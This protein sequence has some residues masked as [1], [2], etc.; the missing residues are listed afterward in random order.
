MCVAY[1]VAG[2]TTTPANGG[3]SQSVRVVPTSNSLK[4]SRLLQSL[5]CTRS[6]IP[7]P[8]ESSC[9]ACAAVTHFHNSFI[10]VVF[11]YVLASAAPT[12]VAAG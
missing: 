10:R 1:R 9:T 7:M 8:R 6:C 4:P 11:L 12:D 2:I 5:S 3:F